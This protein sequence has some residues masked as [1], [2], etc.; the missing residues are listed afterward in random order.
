MKSSVPCFPLLAPARDKLT[1]ELL[2]A[3]SLRRGPERDVLRHA[4]RLTTRGAPANAVLFGAASGATAFGVP[5]SANFVGTRGSALIL[6]VILIG[7]SESEIFCGAPV[8]AIF[9]G[10][11][12]SAKSSERLRVH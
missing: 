8:G 6:G 3:Q 7:A 1:A 2:R 10:A 5:A 4:G 11:P 12:V 9:V